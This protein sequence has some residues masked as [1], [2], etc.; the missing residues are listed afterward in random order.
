MREDMEGPMGKVK[1][2]A[3]VESRNETQRFYSVLAINQ[4]HRMAW[5]GRDFKDKILT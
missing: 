4:S 1:Q 2:G 3:L 5:A